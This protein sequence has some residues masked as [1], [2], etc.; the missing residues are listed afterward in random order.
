VVSSVIGDSGRPPSAENMAKLWG[1]TIIGEDIL[2][3]QPGTKMRN[4]DLPL[5]MSDVWEDIER[6]EIGRLKIGSVKGVKGSRFRSGS[7]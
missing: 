3:H 7:R 4:G 2:C 5:F 1:G 6:E